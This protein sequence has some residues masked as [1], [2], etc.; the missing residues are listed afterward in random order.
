MS[1]YTKEEIDKYFQG[2]PNGGTPLYRAK[3]FDEW[4][5]QWKARS[6]DVNMDN[7]YE[8]RRF[9]KANKS[10]RCDYSMEQTGM[11]GAI[12]YFR[13]E[14]DYMAAVLTVV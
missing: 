14:E 2:K 13:N 5:K 10:P 6:I 11:G 1:L 12:Y 3:K 8:M 9:L 7:F 4:R